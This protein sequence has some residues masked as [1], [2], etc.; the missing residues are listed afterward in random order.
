MKLT[1]APWL[2][3]RL[4]QLPL[5]LRIDRRTP[6]VVLGL[7]ILAGVALIVNV[8][9]GEYRVP[10]LEVVKTI[11]GLSADPDYTFVV[12]TLRLPRALVALLVGMGLAVA[13]AIMQGLTRNPLAAPEIVGINSGASLV[14]VALIVL[15]PTAPIFSLPVAAF[16]GGLGAAIAIYLL[17]WNQ[18]SAP[19]RLILV[20]V[21][22]T[23]FTGSLT[24]LMITFGNIYNVSQALV[25]L[26]G[27]VYGRSWE[28]LWPLLIPLMVFLPLS[29]LLARD[30]DTL[31]LGDDLALGLGNRVEQKRSLL[32]LCTVALAGSAV[33]IAG[34]V[35]FVGLMAPHL[36]RHWVGASHSGLM[37]TAALVGACLVEL[38]DVLGRLLFAPIELPCGVITAAIGAPYFLWLLYRDGQR[39]TQ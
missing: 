2:T 34:N 31:N 15:V 13:G 38:A 27:S 17:A 21:G 22:L 4:R 3:L 5:S 20:G 18:G 33:A 9:Q 24:S 11:L 1:P 7:T 12:N 29:L 39:A 10:P 30:L 37:P 14:A 6:A 8:S 35:G 19:I 28:H 16:M 36:A 23:A 25:W 32:L 26:T